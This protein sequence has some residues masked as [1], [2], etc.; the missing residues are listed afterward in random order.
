M[1]RLLSSLSPP[2]RRQLHDLLARFID[3]ASS[4]G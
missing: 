4:S 2:E 3:H 1:A